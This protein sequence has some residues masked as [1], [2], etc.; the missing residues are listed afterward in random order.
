MIGTPPSPIR[1]SKPALSLAWWLSPSPPRNP[2]SASMSTRP[3]EASS[4]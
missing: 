2:S 4:Q 1:A 3:V